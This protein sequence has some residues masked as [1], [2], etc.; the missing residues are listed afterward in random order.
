MTDSGEL[1]IDL[2]LATDNKGMFSGVTATEV[3]TPSEPHL[4][5][6]MKALR[7]RLDARSISA[8][9]WMDTRDMV[10][11]AMTKG[12]LS[13]EPLLLLWKTAVLRF[14]GETPVVWRSSSARLKTVDS[15]HGGEFGRDT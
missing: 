10:C 1:P 14:I 15:A 11:D 8:L 9:W 12:T 2:E 6:I 3:K 4:L 13:R 7:D 5:Y